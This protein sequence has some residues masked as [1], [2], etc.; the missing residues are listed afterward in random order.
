MYKKWRIKRISLGSAVKIGGTVSCITGFI[1][2]TLAGFWMVLFSTIIGSLI[3]TD[4]FRIG[5]DTLFFI[6]L[7]FALIYGLVGIM[8]SFLIA[9][10]YNLAS[11]ILGGVQLEMD[12]GIKQGYKMRKR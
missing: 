6:P 5:F 10:L 4:I 3:D 7:L 9:L 11:G 8:F 12:D 2:G 1:F